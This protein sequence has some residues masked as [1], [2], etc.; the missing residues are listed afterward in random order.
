MEI[1]QG[2]PVIGTL[3]G[4]VRVAGS[5]H[6]PYGI[7]SPDVSTYNWIHNGKVTFRLPNHPLDGYPYQYDTRCI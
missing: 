4:H 2:L 7:T 1:C 5:L 3:P 6:I